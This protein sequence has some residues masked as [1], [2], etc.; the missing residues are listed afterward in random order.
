M[1]QVF[2]NVMF[3][4]ILVLCGFPKLLCYFQE[5]LRVMVENVIYYTMNVHMILIHFSIEFSR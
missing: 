1:C 2:I 4:L 5:K 3:M